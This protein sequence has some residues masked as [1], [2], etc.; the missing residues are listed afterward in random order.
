MEVRDFAESLLFGRDIEAKLLRPRELTDKEPGP[1]LDRL[2]DLPF[3]PAGLRFLDEGESRPREARFPGRRALARD[4]ER[5]RVMHFFANHELLALELMA[6]TLLRF[7]DAPVEFR[8]TLV[9]VMID[10]QKHLELYLDR[11]A[12]L[13]GS[14]GDLP[15][16]RFFWD[17]LKKVPTPRHFLAGMSLGFEQ[18][19][20]DFSLHYIDTLREHDD[21]ETLGVLRRV[22]EDEIRHVRRGLD[23]FREDASDEE[24]FSVYRAHLAFPLG[25]QHGRARIFSR[26]ARID[27]GLPVPF[28]DEMEAC[29][30]SRGRPPRVRFMNP[31]V[32]EEIAGRPQIE[33]LRRADRDLALMPALAAQAGDVVLVPEQPSIELRLDL[34][35]AGLGPVDWIGFEEAPRVLAERP[36][37]ALA[38]FGRSPRSAAFA[39]T[40]GLEEVGLADA[41][42]FAK[43]AVPALRTLLIES[44]VADPAADRLFFPK[45]EVVLDAATAIARAAGGGVIVKPVLSSAG[46]RQLRIRRPIR[47]EAEAA[48]LTAR[49]ESCGP[50]VVE[51]FLDRVA[52]LSF[53]LDRLESGEL[54]PRGLVRFHNDDQGQF[55]SA[56][57]AQAVTTL[58]PQAQRFL[59][60]E[61][62]TAGWFERLLD[63]LKEVLG[64]RLAGA[65]EAGPIGVDMMIVRDRLGALRLQPLVE[66]NP[67]W[68]LGRLALEAARRI[69]RG[70]PGRLLILR[71]GRDR[72]EI[73][74]A[75]ELA[76]DL[77]LRLEG[78]PPLLVEGLILLG[79]DETDRRLLPVLAV[80]EQPIRLLGP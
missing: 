19:N 62:R 63:R 24:L 70:V 51:E 7:P 59:A 11:M 66:I 48:G 56:E 29:A 20:L 54:R 17:R 53:H 72:D 18:A 14:L 79:D 6:L 65:S 50:F 43:D 32:E 44:M 5:A 33:A 34:T 57:T 49:L 76:G 42:L 71:R 8:R 10:E 68:T 40:L 2:P 16:G 73:S 9:G 45:T 15:C 37:G 58:D 39:R 31:A 23:L 21:A 25:P 36:L 46:R 13:G 3:R 28:I 47:D 60:G 55:L 4:R 12:A 30:A 1:A 64:A 77:P 61:G 69:R 75:C 26:E 78:S 52:D 67:R 22:H 38:P 80:G 74:R 35:R 41:A 27:A